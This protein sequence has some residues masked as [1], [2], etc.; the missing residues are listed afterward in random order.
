[1]KLLKIGL[2]FWMA[3]TS[4]FSFVVGWIML[5]HAPKPVQTSPSALVAATPLPTLAPL[6]PLSAFNSDGGNFQGQP[7]P[8][9]QPR[10]RSG[11]LNSFFTTGGS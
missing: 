9:I 11:F 3:L 10:N 2:H 4:L 8:S 1:M 5:A 7:L 6:P